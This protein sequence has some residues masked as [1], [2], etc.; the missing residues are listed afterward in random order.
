M[1]DILTNNIG[2][3]KHL[4]YPVSYVLRRNEKRKEGKI[5]GQVV[6]NT[7]QTI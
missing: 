5:D 2:R 6:A 7:S 1:I 3:K 4:F